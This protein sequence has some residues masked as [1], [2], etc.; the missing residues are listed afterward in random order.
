MEVL[1]RIEWLAS[2]HIPVSWFCARGSVAWPRVWDWLYEIF[3]D[4][5]VYIYSVVCI[6]HVHA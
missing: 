2:F 6:L 5:I 3:I 1:F 4:T